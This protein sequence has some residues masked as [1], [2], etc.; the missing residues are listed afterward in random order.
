MRT[1]NAAEPSLFLTPSRRPG[2]LAIWAV[3]AVLIVIV[4]GEFIVRTTGVSSW[5]ST[6][7]HSLNLL[8]TGVVGLLATAMYTVFEPPFAIA[9]TVIIAALIWALTRNFRL[10]ISFGAVV[11]I[12]WL[13]VVVVKTLVHRPRPNPLELAHPFAV[14]PDASYPSGH[15]AFVTALVVVLILL[16]RGHR[17]YKWIVVLGPLLVILLALALAIDGVHFP[18]D[19]IAS[20]VWSAGLA[21]FVLFLWARFVVPLTQR[22][23]RAGKEIA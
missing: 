22:S 20:T 1:P 21:P 14:Q 10:G 17:A 12:T 7:S 3:I 23:Q 16:S 2:A 18:T 11:A 9:I 4:F 19:V 6:V 8:H 15:V 5:D 13:P